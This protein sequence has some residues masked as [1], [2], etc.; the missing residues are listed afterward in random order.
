MNETRVRRSW[1]AAFVV[2][3][4][5]SFPHPIGGVVLDLGP[6]VSWQRRRA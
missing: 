6:F 4:F 2:A 1:L 5:L 3:T